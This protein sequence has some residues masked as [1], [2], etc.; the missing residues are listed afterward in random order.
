MTEDEEQAKIAEL[1]KA[2]LKLQMAVLFACLLG[3]LTILRVLARAYAMHLSLIKGLVYGFL[4]AFWFFLAG[5]SLYSRSRW[6]FIGLFAWTVIPLFGLLGLSVRLLRL[7][8]EATLTVS[9]PDTI[10]CL[11]AFAQ[12][13]ATCV[14]LRYLLAKDVRDYVWKS[15]A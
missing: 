9:W 7:T 2:P 11:V 15:S 6:G 3:I 12:F 1:K 5:G 8:L 13:V 4:L 10:L 14:L